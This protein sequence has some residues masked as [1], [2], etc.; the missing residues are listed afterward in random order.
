MR[1][2]SSGVAEHIWI[3]GRQGPLALLADILFE[4]QIPKSQGTIDRDVTINQFLQN[5][6]PNVCGSSKL[7]KDLARLIKTSR[8]HNVELTA[9]RLTAKAKGS[10]PVWYHIG[11]ESHPGRLHARLT[12]ECLKHQHKT[13]KV[14]DMVVVILRHIKYYDLFITV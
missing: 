6:T 14:K 1:P 4:D 8:K 11:S 3:W 12:S 7:P 9:L 5:W 10:L 13:M 2:S